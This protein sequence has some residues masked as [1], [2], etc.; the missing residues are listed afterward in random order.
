M[1]KRALALGVLVLLGLS[2]WVP[3]AAAGGGGGCH[4]GEFNDVRGAKVNLSNLCFTPTVIRI[5]PGQTVT[6]TNVDQMSHTVT[7]AANRW[8]SYDEL[9]IKKTA[10]YRFKS[11]GVFPYFC[12]YHPG[13]VGAV[14]VGDGTSSE[15]TTQAVV[16]VLPSVAAPTVAPTAVPQPAPASSTSEGVSS[17]WR[18]LAITAF[19]LFVVAAAGLA[20]QRLVT[21]RATVKA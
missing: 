13:M 3:I 21:R 18:I 15:T 10:T 14:V 5:E 9:G 12:A 7:G 19:A 11:S 8:G 17:L 4:S 1:G 20:A 16:P 6:W 2:L